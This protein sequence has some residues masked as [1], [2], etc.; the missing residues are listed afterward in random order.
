MSCFFIIERYRFRGEFSVDWAMA[1]R[2]ADQRSAT[3]HI[4]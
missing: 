4:S 1:P 3:R 2:H